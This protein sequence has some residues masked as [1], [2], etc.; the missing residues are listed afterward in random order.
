[1]KSNKNRIIT[2]ALLVLNVIFAVG[3]LITMNPLG[4]AN[5]VVAAVLFY[6]LKNYKILQENY[7]GVE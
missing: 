1:M 4:I 6:Q 2:I 5:A 3:M 7:K